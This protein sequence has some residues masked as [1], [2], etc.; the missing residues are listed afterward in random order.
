MSKIFSSL[1]TNERAAWLAR[2]SFAKLTLILA[3]PTRR[4]GPLGFTRHVRPASC[5]SRRTVESLA[6]DAM[7]RLS[8]QMLHFREARAMPLHGAFAMPQRTPCASLSSK[9]F[10]RRFATSRDERQRQARHL[11]SKKCLK[12]LLCQ[13]IYADNTFPKIFGERQPANGEKDQKNRIG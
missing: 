10:W 13:G 11:C 7:Q 8:A 2:V 12:T 4:R 6:A 1:K 5:K 3:S 9:H